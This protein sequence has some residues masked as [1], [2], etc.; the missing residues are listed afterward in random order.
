MGS[1]A[2]ESFAIIPKGPCAAGRMRLAS[3]KHVQKPVIPFT[4]RCAG[5]TVRRIAMLA[6]RTPVAC[7]SRGRGHAPEMVTR[8]A[9]VGRAS[10]RQSVGSPTAVRV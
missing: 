4:V 2:K 8:A 7:P 1:V 6:W 10:V 3:V 5:V 9:A